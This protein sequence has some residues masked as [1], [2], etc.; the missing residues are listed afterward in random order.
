MAVDA[1]YQSDVEEI[2]S[3]RQ[4][5]GADYWTT[6]DKRLLK[7]SPFS[8]YQSAQLLL[9]LGVD[10]Q[11]PVLQAVAELFFSTWREDGQFRLYPA[12]TVFPCQTAYAAYL[13]CHLGY[14]GDARVE[15]NLQYLLDTQYGDGGW[16]CNKFFFG[17]GPETECSNPMPTLVALDAFRFTKRLN[18]EPALDRAAEFLLQH[19]VIRKPIGPCHYGMGTRFMQVEYPFYNYNLFLYVYV[20]SFYDAAKQDKRFLE[21]LEA[22]QATLVDGQI[23]AQRVVPKLAKLNFCRKGQPSELGTRRYREILEN[24]A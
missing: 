20:L 9:E 17:H 13:L 12:G 1:R 2:L 22:L 18:R 10:P 15:K 11:D 16:R 4:D 7:G 23:V 5:N 3:H 21:A 24:L 6:P 14:A 8:A 19:W